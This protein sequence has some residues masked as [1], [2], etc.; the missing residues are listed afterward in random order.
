MMPAELKGKGYQWCRTCKII[1]PPRASHCSACNHCVLRF[2]HH[3]PVVNNCIAQRN[4]HFFVGFL[5]S[6]LCSIMLGLPVTLL[7]VVHME[8]EHARREHGRKRNT[9]IF[10]IES[11]G[12]TNSIVV[13]LAMVVGLMSVL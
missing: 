13:G 8:S 6:I 5:C 9:P 4:Y 3:C 7:W 2:D 10:G 11:K 12:I 1:R